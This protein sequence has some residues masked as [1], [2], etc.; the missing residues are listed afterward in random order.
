[1]PETTL[2]AK[3]SI[4]EALNNR[5][6]M[7]EIEIKTAKGK[8][9]KYF[10]MEKDCTYENTKLKCAICYSVN[11]EETKERTI[12]N[13]VISE[14]EALQKLSKTYSKTAFACEE[15]ANKEILRLLKKDL[16]KVKYHNVSINISVI[17]KRKKG[18]QPKDAAK[19]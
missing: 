11:L 7:K 19:I 17:E 8:V 9:S 15:D 6:Q 2:L 5:S 18:G 16:K 1:M 14:K 13:R 3:N 12:S 4:R 10:V